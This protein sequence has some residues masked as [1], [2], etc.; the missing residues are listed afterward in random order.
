MKLKIEQLSSKE[1]KVAK[2]GNNYMVCGIK[3][4]K[5]YGGMV[6]GK[7]IDRFN[8]LKEGME[9][10][11]MTF[12]EDWEGKEYDKWKFPAR[13]DLLEERVAALEVVLMAKQAPE[14]KAPENAPMEQV[15]EQAEV[16]PETIEN[17][18]NEPDNLPF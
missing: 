16:P 3:A 10:D 17:K 4:D 8:E 9:V 1:V 14:K 12:K 15:D 13:L 2:N 11:V 5:W 18:E 6:W 7:D